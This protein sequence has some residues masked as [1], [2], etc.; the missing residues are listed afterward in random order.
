MLA[1]LLPILVILALAALT[2]VGAWRLAVWAR[3]KNWRLG[4]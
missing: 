1:Y 3:G 4:A 2:C